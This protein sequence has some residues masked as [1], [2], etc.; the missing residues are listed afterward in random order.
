MLK[1]IP[2]PALQDNYIWLLSNSQNCAIVVDP[3]IAQPVLQVLM[4]EKLELQAIWITHHHHDHSG[5]AMEISQHFSVPIYGP[6]HDG[7][8]ELLTHPLTEGQTLDGLGVPFSIIDCPGHTKGHIAFY[9]DGKLFCGDT[10][11]TAGCGRLF[12]GT[13]AQLYHS[14]QKFA[15]LPDDTL[16]YCGHEYTHNNLRFAKTVEPNNAAVIKRMQHVQ[17][18]REKNLPTVPASLIIEK[19]TN[20]FLRCEELSVIKAAQNYLQKELNDPISVFA[21]LRRWKDNFN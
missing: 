12:E 17:T 10:L 8:E 5:G 6:A 13:A 20:P 2:L 18:L 14:L 7:L 4:K 21:A 11:F 15:A 16:I 9:G 19:Q 1:I 3:G